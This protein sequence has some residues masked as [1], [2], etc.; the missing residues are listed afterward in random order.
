MRL[1]VPMLAVALASSTALAGPP[2]KGATKLPEGYAWETNYEQARLKA[3][4][5]GKLLFIDFYTDW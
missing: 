2:K 5:S 3:A 4:E 1:I